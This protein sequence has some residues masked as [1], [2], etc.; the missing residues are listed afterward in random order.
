MFSPQSVWHKLR[1]TGARAT[2][3]ALCLAAGF[4]V[5]ADG[6]IPPRHNAPPMPARSTTIS[7]EDMVILSPFTGD[8][9]MAVGVPFGEDK[10]MPVAPDASQ[11][12]STPLPAPVSRVVQ[13]TSDHQSDVGPATA[14]PIDRNSVAPSITA[15]P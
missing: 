12:Q 7:D 5:Q 9:K 2:V 6:Q 10:A 4:A 1:G 13:V 15:T 14:T 11:P 8:Q 3:V